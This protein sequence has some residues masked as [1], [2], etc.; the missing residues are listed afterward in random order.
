MV[1]GGDGHDHWHIRRVATYR[2]FA[3][4]EDGQVVP[5]DKG[6]SDAKIGFCFFDFE[7]HLDRGPMAALYNRH[8]CGKRQDEAVDMGLSP[9]WNDTYDFALPG[10]S[11]DIE[12]LP[13]GPYRLRGEADDEGQFREVSRANNVTWVDLELE[14]TPEGL[15]TALVT[16]V[17]PHPR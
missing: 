3:L 14:T 4:D 2:L 12:G 1:W 15:R 10:Q 9:G 17:G 11:I 6:R 7:R 13:D 5:G 8:S 16:D